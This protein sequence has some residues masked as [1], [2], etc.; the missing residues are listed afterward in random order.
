MIV[1]RDM[2]CYFVRHEIQLRAGAWLAQ[3]K[4]ERTKR[5]EQS[6]SLTYW[7][8][9]GSELE[10]YQPASNWAGL[11]SLLQAFCLY[12]R[13]LSGS[14]LV[15]LYPFAARKQLGMSGRV[16]SNKRAYMYL[17]S[18]I[19]IIE[20][21]SNSHGVGDIHWRCLLL[22]LVASEVK[23]DIINCFFA[24]MIQNTNHVSLIQV[25]IEN[26]FISDLFTYSDP[27]TLSQGQ[28]CMFIGKKT[29]IM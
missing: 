27:W 18:Y 2:T 9:T 23:D 29:S 16:S 21:I 5:E 13:T 6:A 17:I 10:K 20:I 4:T 8:N 24:H 11:T 1:P 26:T 25:F 12:R 22:P 28:A 15:G 19:S 7:I 14:L 3:D